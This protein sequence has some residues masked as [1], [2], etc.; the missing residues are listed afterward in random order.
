MG[1]GFQT[2]AFDVTPRAYRQIIVQAGVPVRWT[3]NATADSLTGC[4]NA[5]V[6]PSLGLEKALIPGA[7]LVEFTPSSAGTIPYSCWMGMIR[8]KIIVV[9]SLEG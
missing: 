2:V 1:D 5:I 7:N 8:S 3:L 9:E 4:N 6:V